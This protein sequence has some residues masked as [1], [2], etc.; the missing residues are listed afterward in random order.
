[1]FLFTPL[2][3]KSCFHACVQHRIQ[4]T[5]SGI[6]STLESAL[7]FS[8]KSYFRVSELGSNEAHWSG[9][10]VWVPATHPSLAAQPKSTRPS[11]LQ[12]TFCFFIIPI[13]LQPPH[14]SSRLL[15]L[16]RFLHFSNLVFSTTAI[17]SRSQ[18]LLSSCGEGLAVRWS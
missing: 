13:L 7:P 1:M 12:H 11:R 17:S 8:V 14:F 15:V 4:I 18:Y 2:L 16:Y 9:M 10:H 5:Q 3:K 6:Q